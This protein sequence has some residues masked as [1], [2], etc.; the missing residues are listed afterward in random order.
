MEEDEGGLLV[1]SVV[2]EKEL[3]GA[4][5]LVNVEERFDHAV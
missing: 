4:D 1:Q 5:V 3:V 2:G